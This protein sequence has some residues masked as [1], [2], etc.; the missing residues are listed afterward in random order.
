[1]TLGVETDS[2][3]STGAV[4]AVREVPPVGERDLRTLE[5]EFSGEL[6]QIPPMFSALKRDGVRLYKL[7]RQG[8]EVPRQP[9]TIRIDA[10]QLRQLNSTE[11]SIEATC[12]RG[13]YI[14]TL[15]SDLGK[16]L[17]CGAHLKSLRRL[18]CGRLSINQATTLNELEQLGSR[19]ESA[20]ISLAVALGHLRGIV[21]ENR[22]IDRLRMGQQEVLQPIGKPVEKDELLRIIDA[23]GDLVALI[24]WNEEMPG[25]G[26]R[27]LRV[28]TH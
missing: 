15:A 26:W 11:I 7:A 21:W 9:R 8:R 27:L 13:T 25:G 24:G 28:F 23:R 16:A 14:R 20:L 12:S 22:W 17:G 1:M 10:I 5:Q 4:I 18:A 19:G 6:Q 2:Q 3:D